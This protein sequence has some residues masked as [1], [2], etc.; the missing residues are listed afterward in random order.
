MDELLDAPALAAAAELDRALVCQYLQ[1]FSLY[2]PPHANGRVPRW[3]P[4]CVPTLQL[5]HRLHAAGHTTPE[6]RYLLAVLHIPAP[7]EDSLPYEV[8]P[9][10]PSEPPALRGFGYDFE[11]ETVALRERLYRPHETPPQTGP[12]TSCPRR[13]WWARWLR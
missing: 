3:A 2:L 4:E 10:P 1:D 8:P 11:A 5:I 6:I 7:D 12:D 13:P 9:P